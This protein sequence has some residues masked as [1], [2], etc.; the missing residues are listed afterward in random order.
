MK[1]MTITFYSCF[2]HKSRLILL[3]SSGQ[4]QQPVMLNNV[5]CAK[6]YAV[7]VS[8]HIELSE[9]I[10]HS[11]SADSSTVALEIG[12]VNSVRVMLLQESASAHCLLRG[13]IAVTSGSRSLV[14]PCVASCL[15]ASC[16]ILNAT[17]RLAQTL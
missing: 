15:I 7:L 12:I 9:I 5:T 6:S 8:K 11:T 10:Y 1:N 2:N 13:Y 17:T 4:D 14:H 3:C 16:H